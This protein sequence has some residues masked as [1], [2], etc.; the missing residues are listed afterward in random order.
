MSSQSQS[1]PRTEA[2]VKQK[3]PNESDEVQKATV[4]LID[5]LKRRAMSSAKAAGDWTQESYLQAVEQAKQS[6]A[7]TQELGETYRSKL[8]DSVE[9]IQEEAQ[10]NWETLQQEIDEFGDRISEAA[11]AAWSILTRSNTGTS[12]TDTESGQS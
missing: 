10:S 9:L 5:A 8:N 2:L 11:D 1:S 7:Q 12:S 4:E 6:I 3:M